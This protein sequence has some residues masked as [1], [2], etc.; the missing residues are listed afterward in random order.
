VRI[1][2]TAGVIVLD[3]AQRVLL[4]HVEDRV[5]IDLARP[6][7]TN[8][9]GPPGGGVEPAETFEAAGIR[10]LWE[11][12]G[13]RVPQLGPWVATYERTIRFPDEDVGFHIRYFVVHVPAS[14]VDVSN[15]LPDERSLYRAHRWWTLEQIEQSVE[16]FL[17]PQLPT[18]LRAII[19]GE[20]P[21]Q[22]MVLR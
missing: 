3:D 11:E 16:A 6:D 1:R 22:P 7:L 19:S 21:S 9:W 12:T 10:E 5:A 17:P 15:M 20:L 8:W 2:P 13:L 4:L 14:D 18:L